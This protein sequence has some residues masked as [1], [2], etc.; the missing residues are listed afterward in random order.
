MATLRRHRGQTLITA[1][2]I[3]AVSAMIAAAVTAGVGLQSGFDRAAGRA[4]LPDVIA[5]FDNR[6]LA[7]VRRRVGALPNIAAVSYRLRERRVHVS[8]GDGRRIS[9]GQVE[10]VRPGRRGYA[11]VSGRDLSGAPGEA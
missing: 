2:G 5:T 4:D 10:G 8:G 6:N 7:A 11:V 9:S 3:A 1:A